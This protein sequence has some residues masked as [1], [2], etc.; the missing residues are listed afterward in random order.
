MIKE[1]N[2]TIMR[3]IFIASCIMIVPLILYA[4]IYCAVSDAK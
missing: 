1:M 2:G 3:I 4:V